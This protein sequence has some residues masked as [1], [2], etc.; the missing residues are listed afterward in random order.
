[1]PL[2]Y[3][4]LLRYYRDKRRLVIQDRGAQHTGPPVEAVLK[5]AQGR[6]TLTPHPADSPEL[7]PAKRIWK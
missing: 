5:A 7:N 1:V 4:N 6:R 3:G 2:F